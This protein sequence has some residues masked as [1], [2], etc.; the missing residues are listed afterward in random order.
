MN[1]WLILALAAALPWG[2]VAQD[3]PQQQLPNAPSA[4]RYPP[5]PPDP[6][7]AAQPNPA[8][9]TTG[10]G[11]PAARSAK[12]QFKCGATRRFATSHEIRRSSEHQCE[13]ASRLRRARRHADRDPQARRRGQRCLHRHR[14]ARSLC[15]RPH[16]KR[17]PGHRRQQAG[18]TSRRSA[19]KPIC[20][21]AWGC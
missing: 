9:Q 12:Q 2:V 7:P 21:C 11:Q 10:T 8:P 1:Y 19:T 5:P 17:F 6:P 16:A 3:A 20:R 13:T 14:Q 4:V 18:A 15:E